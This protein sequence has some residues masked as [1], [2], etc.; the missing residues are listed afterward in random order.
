MYQTQIE[1]ITTACLLALNNYTEHYFKVKM[2]ALG[3]VWLH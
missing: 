3:K 2:T 1:N